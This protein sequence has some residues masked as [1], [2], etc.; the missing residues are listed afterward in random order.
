[1]G[2]RSLAILIGSVVMLNVG[3]PAVALSQLKSPPGGTTPAGALFRRLHPAPP[4]APP[5]R[6]RPSARRAGDAADGAER[7]LGP[8]SPRPGP[9]N[10]RAGHG[11]GALGAPAERPPGLHAAAERA[12]HE[13]RHRQLPRGNP[14]ARPREASPVANATPPSGDSICVRSRAESLSSPSSS[15]PAGRGRP[16]RRASRTGSSR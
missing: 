7:H 10:R 9:G 3:V 6:P 16:T 2:L 8:G 12:G 13:R 14:A 5:P 15:V 11:A 4:P 1:M